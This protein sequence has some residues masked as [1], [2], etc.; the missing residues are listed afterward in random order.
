MTD[1]HSEVQHLA[2]Q[3]SYPAHEPRADDPHYHYFNEARA[4]LKKAGKLT[5]WINN[6]DCKGGIELHHNAVEFALANEVDISRFAE[7]YPEFAI[8]DDEDFYRVIES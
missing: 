5:C 4:R 3:Y 7:L 8:K 1:A 6:A 2:L